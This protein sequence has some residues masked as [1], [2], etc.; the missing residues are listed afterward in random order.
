MVRNLERLIENLNTIWIR[1]VH[2][3]ANPAC[4]E[5]PNAPLKQNG[6]TPV[7]KHNVEAEYK[8]SKG[9]GQTNGHG[10]PGVNGQTPV[11]VYGPSISPGPAMVLDD[12]C[13]MERDWSNNY[14]GQAKDIT[15]ISNL[16]SLIKDEGFSIVNL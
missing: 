7:P 4:Y 11:G 9:N 14:M 3:I 13:A 8:V 2:L 15:S 5:R 10:F 12:S 1:R 6:Y 16:K